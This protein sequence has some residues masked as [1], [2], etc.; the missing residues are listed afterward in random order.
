MGLDEVMNKADFTTRFS[1]SIRRSSLVSQSTF[2]LFGSL[3]SHSQ[4]SK[5]CSRLLSCPSSTSS[6]YTPKL[7]RYPKQSNSLRT[8]IPQSAHYFPPVI[9]HVSM[10]PPF[11]QLAHIPNS[12]ARYLTFN[13]HLIALC[14]SASDPL[15][16]A[17]NWVFR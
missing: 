16:V 14:S 7:P 15:V 1:L 3:Y 13:P 11:G 17:S 8:H 12:V 2:S 4:S 5:L 10:E 9:L 6:S